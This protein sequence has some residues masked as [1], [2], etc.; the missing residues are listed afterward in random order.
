MIGL[1]GSI[2]RELEQALS[3]WRAGCELTKISLSAKCQGLT[4]AVI[5][6]CDPESPRLRSLMQS[7]NEEAGKLV[8]DS[9]AEARMYVRRLDT[10][11]Q[12]SGINAA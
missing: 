1:S 2:L 10:S 12:T 9:F 6:R 11:R 7:H 3:S 4:F 8:D 5:I